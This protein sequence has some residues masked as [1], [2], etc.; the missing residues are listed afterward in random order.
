MLER[1]LSESTLRDYVSSLSK[2]GYVS[3]EN[4][5]TDKRMKVIRVIK[6]EEE[7]LSEY[8][9]KQFSDCF[10]LDSFKEWLNGYEKYS[11]LKPEIHNNNPNDKFGDDLESIFNQHYTG[12]NFE[13]KDRI[14]NS[15]KTSPSNETNVEK[16]QNYKTTEKDA[17]LRPNSAFST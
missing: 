13:K 1:P 10:T 16:P 11:V 12:V 2:V 15:P 5:P 7:N 3:E 8:V 4:H 6:K 17:I 14:F 9:R